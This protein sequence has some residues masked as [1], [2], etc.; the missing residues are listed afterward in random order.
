MN[1]ERIT[2]TLTNLTDAV[3]DVHRRYRVPYGRN[4]TLDALE[5]RR[6]EV[7]A[8]ISDLRDEVWGLESR[9]KDKG[10]KP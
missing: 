4:E 2:D 3:V 7:E 9:P 10:E 6:Q 1:V 8:L 5:D